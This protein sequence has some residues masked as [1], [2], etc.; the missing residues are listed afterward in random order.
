MQ[1]KTFKRSKSGIGGVG[2]SR[3]NIENFLASDVYPC[4]CVPK[5]DDLYGSIVNDYSCAAVG[6]ESINEAHL[7]S[8]VH[9]ISLKQRVRSLPKIF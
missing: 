7:D 2:W 6:E 3:D 1:R 9:Y 4:V 8:C 5:G